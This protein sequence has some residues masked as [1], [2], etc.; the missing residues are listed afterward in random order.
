MC[1]RRQCD[2]QTLSWGVNFCLANRVQTTI[3]FAFATIIAF[4]HLPATIIFQLTSYYTHLIYIIGDTNNIRFD[5]TD[6]GFHFLSGVACGYRQNVNIRPRINT[7]IHDMYYFSHQNIICHAS[8][9]SR[10]SN[11]GK[12]NQFQGKM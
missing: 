4:C 6:H 8:N 12:N 1:H 10:P 5:K 11:D 7:R 3:K 2:N 9:N